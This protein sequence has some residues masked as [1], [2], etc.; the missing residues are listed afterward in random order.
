MTDF[1]RFRAD[2]EEPAP[3]EAETFA[4]IAKTFVDEGDA[5]MKKEG[6]AKR[7]SHASLV[8]T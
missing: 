3:D 4:K 2:V 5:V 7:T 1:V 6:A 8:R